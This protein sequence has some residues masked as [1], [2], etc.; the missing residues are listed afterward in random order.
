MYVCREYVMFMQILTGGLKLQDRTMKD[1]ACTNSFRY[2]CTRGFVANCPIYRSRQCFFLLTPA[3][4]CST[5]SSSQQPVSKHNIILTT[6][7]RTWNHQIRSKWII[8]YR[9]DCRWGAQGMYHYC[10]VE[11]ITDL[12]AHAQWT[13]CQW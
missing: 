3:A 4:L 12:A 10:A 13:E 11:N 8:S 5:C 7:L 1:N 2:L 9:L 6:V